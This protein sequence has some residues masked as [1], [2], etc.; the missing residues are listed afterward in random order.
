MRSF[1]LYLD[2]SGQFINEEK[3]KSPSLIGG[4][5]VKEGELTIKKAQTIMNE[6]ISKTGENYVHIND[7]SKIDKKLAGKVAVDIISQIRDMQAHIVIFENNELLDFKDDKLLYLNI[8]A[9]GIINLLE[10]LSLE[11]PDTVELNVIAAVRRDL[12]IDDNQTI[13]EMQEYSNRI[14]EKIYMKIAEKDLF[15][16]KNCKV[17]F[18][19]SSARKNEK[20]MIAD[21]ICNTRLTIQSEK[22]NSEQ[23]EYLLKTYNSSKYIFNVFRTNIQKKLSEYLIQNNIV[24]AIFLLNDID[25]EKTRKELISLVINNINNMP[26]SNLRIQLELLSLKIRSIID[27][28]RNLILCEKLL[29]NLQQE[30]IDKIKIKEFIISKLRLDISLYLLTIYTHQGNNIKSKEQ[31]IISKNGLKDISGSWEFLEYYYILKI[32]E[33]I[34][35]NTCFKND[36]TIRILT[37]AIEKFEDILETMQK[38]QEFGTI[39]SDMMAKAVGTRLQA[40]TNLITPNLDEDTKKEY[41][42]KAVCDSNFAITQFVSESDKR[43][44]YQY[45]CMLEI[46]VGN[47]DDAVKFLMKIV[48]M[49]E[50][51]FEKFLKL[52]ANISD[53]SK[54]F[55]MVD[56]LEVMQHAINEKNTKLGIE[57]FEAFKSNLNLYNEY[58]LEQSENESLYENKQKFVGIHPFE[59]IYW[60]LGKFFKQSNKETAIIYFDKAIEICNEMNEPTINVLELAIEA[61]KLSISKHIG[62][63]K[64]VLINKYK[65]IMQ[66]NELVEIHEF[67][68]TIKDEFEIIE[69]F[70][71]VSEIKTACR[72]I[73]TEIKV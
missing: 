22:F 59:I 69:L 49:N 17:N 36:K 62:E 39:K 13:I 41:Y 23:R 10:K 44:Q 26:T 37:E 34:Y 70:D 12:K 4:I 52:V 71:D 46:A 33:A 16:S 58:G 48:G 6:A 7:I 8:M 38:I 60:C 15:L 9:E 2:E 30:I 64:W 40:Y 14:K 3:A 53:F 20:L 63:D 51:N 42:D 1:E 50:R 47:F 61:D 43:R 57:M 35:Y 66:N 31:I 65:N 25:D 32:R 72:K 54:N 19:L 56:Y 27:V 5:L 21:V 24:D 45:R 29:I 73:A 67:L 68:D 28:Q 11:K 18:E 55:I